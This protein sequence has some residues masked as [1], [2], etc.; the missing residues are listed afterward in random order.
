MMEKNK[1]QYKGKKWLKFRHIYGMIML[2]VTVY[3]AWSVFDLL[4]ITPGQQTGVVALGYRMENIQE[5]EESWITGTENFGATLNSVDYVSIFWNTGPVVYVSVRVHPG[6]QLSVAQSAA[7]EVVEYFIAVSNEVVLQYDIQVVVSYG[8]VEVLRAENHAAVVQH[9]HE[10]NHS[11]VEAIL[12]HAEQYPS[13]YNVHRAYRNINAFPNSIRIAVGED[14]L[15]GMRARLEMI[16]I[17]TEVDGYEDQGVENE[18][19][20]YNGENGEEGVVSMPRYPGERQIPR[21]HITDF[22]NWGTWC[23]VRSRISWNERSGDRPTHDNECLDED[24][25]PDEDEDETDNP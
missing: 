19:D 21:S 2:A 5:L 12:A 11:L 6:T 25:C 23:N 15:A 18:G 22:P 8:D 13:E 3:F 9:V 24:E 20:E 7:T 16:D 14:G 1:K 17:V 4:V 10:Y